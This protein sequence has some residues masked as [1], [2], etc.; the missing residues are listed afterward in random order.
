MPALDKILGG[1]TKPARYAGGEWNIQ[2]KP[3]D[4]TP[5][6]IA[7]AFPDIYEIGMSNLAIPILYEIINRQQGMLA[8]RVYAPWIDMEKA[9]R[10]SRLPLFSLETKHPIRDFDILGFSLGYEL[11]YTNVLNMLDLSGIPILAR[12]RDSDRDNAPYPLVIAGGGACFNP[13]PMSDFIDLF[14]IGEGEEVVLELL[15]LYKNLKEQGQKQPPK[16][17]FLRQAANIAGIYVPQFYQAQYYEDSGIL[18]SFNPVIPGIPDKIERRV[19]ETLPAAVTHSVVPYVEVV[20]DRGVVEIQRG[21]TRGCRFCQAG[22]IYRPLRERPVEEVEQAVSQIIRNCGFSEISLLS[23]STSDYAGIENL[24]GDLCRHFQ[25]ENLSLSLPSLRIDNFSVKLMDSLPAK[26]KTGLTFAPEAGTERLRQAI[27]K[28]VS[29]ELIL[30]TV[31]TAYEHGWRS[32]KLYFMIG[33]PTETMDDVDGISDLV[34]KIVHAGKVKGSLP[35][36]RTSVAVF[37]PKPHTPY[38]WLPQE[39][40]ESLTPKYERLKIGLRR[41]KASFSYPDI[42]TSFLEAALSR[43]DRRLGKV[44]QRAFEMGCRFDAWTEKL[45]YAKWQQAFESCGLSMHFYAHR[46]RPLDELLPWSNIDLGVRPAYL[47]REFQR[48]FK[49]QGTPDCRHNLCNVCG[50]EEW[51]ESCKKKYQVLLD[52]KGAKTVELT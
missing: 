31:S 15:E 32:I 37:I 50:M 27:N 5:V 34:G 12:D 28:G 45:D 29:E 41:A 36:V 39:L 13:E 49:D 9:L 1:V 21:C 52:N 18:K 14:V 11:T 8:E 35:R 33:L 42:K 40:L 25:K 19:V 44:I 51:S 17:D 22:V 48:T 30:Q 16:M 20:H 38:Q 24:V 46:Q 23:L 43:G 10:E 47:W 7:I 4:S 6:R 2:I 26:R 3:W